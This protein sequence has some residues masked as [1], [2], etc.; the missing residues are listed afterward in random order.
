[1]RAGIGAHYSYYVQLVATK[2]DLMRVANLKSRQRGGEAGRAQ[3]C[4]GTVIT[5]ISG[6]RLGRERAASPPTKIC[7]RG[8]SFNFNHHN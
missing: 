3:S 6:T 2:R 7:M 4:I 8:N 5:E 1:M